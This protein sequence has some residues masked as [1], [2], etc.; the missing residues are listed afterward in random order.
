MRK[1][2]IRRLEALEKE[3][4]FRERKELSPL[5]SARTYIWVIVLA[6]YLGGLELDEKK[7]PWAE[8]P[9]E[10]DPWEGW[11]NWPSRRPWEGYARALKYASW[12]DYSE[13]V[14][15]KKD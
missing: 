2:I 11:E 4:L 3:P 12:E 8:E 7:G 14:R 13:A 10:D 1:T 9:W 5:K 6:H 15:I